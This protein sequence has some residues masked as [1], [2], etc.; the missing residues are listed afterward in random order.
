MA[1]EYSEFIFTLVKGSVGSVLVVTH[2]GGFQ[3]R[4]GQKNAHQKPFDQGNLELTVVLV[5]IS[6]CDLGLKMVGSQK[7]SYSQ[8]TWKIGSRNLFS[9]RPELYVL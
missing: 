1:D 3:G 5:L 6:H 8:S 4:K 7:A 2:L 9:S